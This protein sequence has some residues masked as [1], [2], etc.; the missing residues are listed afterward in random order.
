MFADTDCSRTTHL[1]A[2]ASNEPCVVR[3]ASRVEKTWTWT[4]ARS[5][6]GRSEGVFNLCTGT[7]MR[8]VPAVAAGFPLAAASV[9]QSGSQRGFPAETESPGAGSAD[10]RNSIGR[11]TTWRTA[12][13]WCTAGLKRA[14]GRTARA[15]AAKAPSVAETVVT[16]PVSTSPRSFTTNSRRTR[17]EVPCRQ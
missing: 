14:L 17:P 7:L 10:G 15:A 5:W 4:V 1:L 16:V 3:D 11:W 2:C 12:R 13:P 8:Q 6:R 9:I